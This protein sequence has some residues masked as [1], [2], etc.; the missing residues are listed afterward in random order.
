MYN[1]TATYIEKTNDVENKE[2]VLLPIPLLEGNT[3]NTAAPL[4]Q[5]AAK[6]EEEKNENTQKVLE[7]A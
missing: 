4:I 7:T 1:N 2:E 6:E 5:T 3:A